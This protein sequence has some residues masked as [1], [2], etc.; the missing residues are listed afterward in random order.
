M[1]YPGFQIARHVEPHLVFISTATRCKAFCEHSPLADGGEYGTLSR[2]N[3]TK[4]SNYRLILLLS[5]SCQV[6]VSIV[7]ATNY[8]HAREGLPSEQTPWFLLGKKKRVDFISIGGCVSRKMRWLEQLVLTPGRH[9]ALGG[10]TPNVA[11]DG[12][13]PRTLTRT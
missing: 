10:A 4:Y 7:Q 11:S 1:P 13:S 5:V 8:P 2:I 12:D 9:T 3:E 6:F